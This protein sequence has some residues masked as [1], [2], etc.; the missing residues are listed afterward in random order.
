[1]RR[2]S[3]EALNLDFINSIEK[4]FNERTSKRIE[5][6]EGEGVS[7]SI[8][9]VS[10]DL[11][12]DARLF[13]LSSFGA[14]LI[15]NLNEFRKYS[16]LLRIGKEIRVNIALNVDKKFKQLAE[17]A[18]IK[19]Q[20]DKNT[21]FFGLRFIHEDNTARFESDVKINPDS[22]QLDPNL[23][24]A[25]FA[26]KELFYKEKAIIRVE[27]ISKNHW[28][29]NAFDTE[30]VLLKDLEL[31][32]YLFL[33]HKDQ[34]YIDAKVTKVLGSSY[35][36]MRFEVF[37]SEI[38]KRIKK[39]LSNHLVSTCEVSP[40]K[41]RNL[42]YGVPNITDNF[43]F[44]YA[45][46]PQEYD[47]V[48]KLR[49]EAY[50]RVGKVKEEATH[51]DMA[52]PLDKLSR[53]LAVFH[54]ETLVASITLT[55]PNSDSLILDTEKNLKDGYPTSFPKKTKMIE[56]ARFCVKEEY[57]K[58][59]LVIRVFQHVYRVFAMSD[60]DLIVSSADDKLLPMYKSIGMK[61]AGVTYDHP[62]FKGIIHHIVSI[63]INNPT[64]GEAMPP[65]RWNYLYRE[66][67]DFLEKR[68]RI[69]PKGFQKVKLSLY[70][71]IGDILAP[72]WREK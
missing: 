29:L 58:S 18:Q 67:T 43:K 22:I 21:C 45:K 42:G 20:E 68:G 39:H 3:N 48:L 53:I 65:L 71:L 52:S 32:I 2:L 9:I 44:R 70:R 35:D 38:P 63:H 19:I 56:I 7:A 28:V 49:F 31:R 27:S 1:M 50:K 36:S 14:G 5:I 61:E 64:A 8:E 15:L 33:P 10:R 37:I 69:H 4:D 25:G 6:R 26:Y 46:T 11:L 41:L 17:I 13:D 60:R 59:H 12:I 34:F 62:V 16:P 40:L 47:D 24:L 51:R 72:L 57:L 30:M 66:M 55:F 54:D 23:P